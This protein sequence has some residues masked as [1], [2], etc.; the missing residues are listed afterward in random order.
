[1]SCVQELVGLDQISSEFKD[2][3]VKLMAVCVDAPSESRKIVKK[4]DLSFPILA[5]EAREA[6]K[7]Y[8][9][10]HA[11]EG[12]KGTDVAIPAHVLIGPDRKILWRHVSRR[13]QDRLSP[14]DVLENVRN[15]AG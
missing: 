7:A 6:I 13:I 14:K 10:V 9:L 4:N 1:M 11:G 12:P 2:A 3:G 15:A 8:G 5:D